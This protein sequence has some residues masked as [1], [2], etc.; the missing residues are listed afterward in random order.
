MVC[1]LGGGTGGGLGSLLAAKIRERHP[2][3]TIN[4]LAVWEPNGVPTAPYNHLLSLRAFHGTATS[5]VL[6][7]QT[8][9]G[10]TKDDNYRKANA[11]IARAFEVASR[12]LRLGDAPVTASNLFAPLLE[13]KTPRIFGLHAATRGRASGSLLS[14]TASLSG[15]ALSEGQ[16]NAASVVMP[17]KRRLDVDTLKSATGWPW[18]DDPPAAVHA[19]TGNDGAV[20]WVAHSDLA[21]PLQTGIASFESLFRRNAFVDHY[22]NEGVETDDFQAAL[23]AAKRQRTRL[24]L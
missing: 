21:V 15:Y 14:A 6:L 10:G 5:V 22:T 17:S 16:L 8:A 7:D 9:I 13:A 19:P 4:V 20:A 23:R 2:S 24:E 1:G 18:S 3:A 12:P 11:R